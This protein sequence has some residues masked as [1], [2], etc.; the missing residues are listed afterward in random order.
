MFI[1]R[2][3][4]FFIVCLCF[5]FASCSIWGKW[6]VRRSQRKGDEIVEKIENYRKTFGRLPESFGDIGLKP[7]DYWKGAATDYCGEMFFYEKLS[8]SE[9]IVYFSLSVGE[10]LYF[11]SC[12]AE[13]SLNP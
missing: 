6:S 13:W 7:D 4:V 2:R 12:R 5:N 10:A 11:N 3:F 8:D 9:Y 1:K